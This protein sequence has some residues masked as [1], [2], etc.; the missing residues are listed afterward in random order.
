MPY[1]GRPAE[2]LSIL[3][4]TTGLFVTL[5]PVSGLVGAGFGLAL[6][7]VDVALV[8]V[9]GGVVGV[10]GVGVGVGVGVAV[11][12]GALDVVVVG[13]EENSELLA[14]GVSVACGAE[15]QPVSAIVMAAKPASP[16]STVRRPKAVPFA[17]RQAGAPPT[18]RAHGKR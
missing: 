8:V 9:F 3:T 17:R 1:C 4:A 18:S 13:A 14:T 15:L 7:V 16:V 6:V 11:G 5:P 2:V 12:V 10:A